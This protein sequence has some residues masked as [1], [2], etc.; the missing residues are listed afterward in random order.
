MILTPTEHDEQVSLF[1]WSQIAACKYPEL[2]LMFAIPN[3]GLRNAIV[4]KKLKAEGVRQ[5]VPDIF[6]PVPRSGFCG[7]FIEMKRVKGGRESQEQ[8]D[9]REAVSAL[10]YRSVVCKGWLEAKG[11]ILEYLR[12]REAV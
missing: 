7:L 9:F 2:T 1:Q 5:G 10:G 3:G 8:K 4:A 12:I 11:T 6:L